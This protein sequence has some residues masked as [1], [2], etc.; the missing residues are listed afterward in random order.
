MINS[1]GLEVTVALRVVT[2][3][4]IAVTG[5]PVG[6]DWFTPLKVVTPAMREKAV[7]VLGVMVIPVP[8]AAAM[9]ASFSV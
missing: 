6:V 2:L 8:V 5:V 1:P 4:E 3:A 7:P 9:P